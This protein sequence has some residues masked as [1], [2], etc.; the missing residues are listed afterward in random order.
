MEIIISILDLILNISLIVAIFS[1]HKRLKTVE[2]KIIDLK[3][4]IG[5][6]KNKID[7]NFPE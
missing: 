5:H 2:E 7:K 6:I 3:F 1:T 4:E